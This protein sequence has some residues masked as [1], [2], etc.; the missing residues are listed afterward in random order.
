MWNTDKI[1]EI[2]WRE[3]GMDVMK[4]D[5]IVP[6]IKRK[7]KQLLSKRNWTFGQLQSMG[8]I[9]DEFTDT[10]YS[11]LEPRE[12]IDLIWHTDIEPYFSAQRP[13]GELMQM[14]VRYSISET[15]AIYLKDEL[16]NANIN[17]NGDDKNEISE[18]SMGRKS[19]EGVKADT[20]KTSE[21]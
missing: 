14:M 3:R 19:P 21:E 2:D 10:I 17:F 18:R 1:E 20:K 12:K 11:E 6:K 9:V 8:S 16:L 4:K 15:I 7:T 13:F 5:V